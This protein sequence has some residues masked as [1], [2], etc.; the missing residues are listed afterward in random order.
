MSGTL[1]A[2]V[3]LGAQKAGTTSL[4]AWLSSHPAVHP[5]AKKEV[6]F[7]DNLW[8]HG[9][10]W[11]RSFFPENLAHGTFTG[12]ATPYYLYHPL[13]PAR[14]AA[15]LPNA[16]FIVLLRDPVARAIS[17]FHHSRRLDLEP[18]TTLEEA[19]AAEPARLS[20]AVE[21]LVEGGAERVHAHQHH[22][23]VDRGR[24]VPQIRR[25]FSFFPREQFLFL[26]SENLFTHPSAA[27]ASVCAFLEIPPV[28]SAPVL[29]SENRG[30]YPPAA[31]QTLAWLRAQFLDDQAAL[32]ALLGPGFVPKE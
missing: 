32:A 15:V 22:S 7:F 14:M 5:G 8:A 16:R 20:G 1:P 21:A 12:E 9:V 17:H 3:I 31:P 29:P 24:Y 4:F 27:V 6:H 30:L 23:Y 26:R 25:W 18:M 13:A 28:L 11:Y 2:F 19:L 10:D